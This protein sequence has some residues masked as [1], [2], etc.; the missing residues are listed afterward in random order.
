MSGLI[1]AVIGWLAGWTTAVITATGYPGI[2]FLM[3]IESACIPLPSEI[4]MPFA[5]YLVS[6]G[7]FSLLGVAT[8]GAIG[9]NIGSAIAYEVGRRGGRPFVERFGRYLLIDA[10]DIDRADRFFARYG[11]W[12]V[13]IGRMLP[14]I[15]TFIAFPA[16]VVRMPLLRFHLFTFIGSWPWCLLLAWIGL[17]LGTAWNSDPRVKAVL[18]SLDVVIVVAVL[19]AVG[20]FIW[21]K[22]RGSRR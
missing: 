4:I 1:E 20:W 3:A 9:N 18:H 8:A 13:L 15:R 19:A 22:T 10:H 16:G 6:I 17:K 5:G 21:H 12:A 14:V 2:A 7:H 11:D